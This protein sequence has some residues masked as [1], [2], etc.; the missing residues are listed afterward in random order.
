[1][2]TVRM[3]KEVD[4]IMDEFSRIQDLREKYIELATNNILESMV[5]NNELGNVS[6]LSL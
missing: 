4:K 2:A 1:M 3:Y 6:K 5:N